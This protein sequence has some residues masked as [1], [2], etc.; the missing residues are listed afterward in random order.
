LEILEKFGGSKSQPLATI[1][2]RFCGEVGGYHGERR[3]PRNGCGVFGDQGLEIVT[4][5]F[6]E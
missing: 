1:P 3:K 6:A 4:A 5:N 2:R